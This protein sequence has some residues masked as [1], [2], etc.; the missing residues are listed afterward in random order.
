[1]KKVALQKSGNARKRAIASHL[2]TLEPRMMFDGAAHQMLD[3]RVVIDSYH[4][5][6]YNQNTGRITA[7]M[8]EAVFESAIQTSSTSR[9]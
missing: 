1:M 6:R 9:P 8:F 2:I 5:S 4:C 3:G 7:E